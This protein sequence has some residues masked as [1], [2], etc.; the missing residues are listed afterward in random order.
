MFKDMLGNMPTKTKEHRQQ[1]LALVPSAPGEVLDGNA[2][3][4]GDA[5]FGH[6]SE[7]G[8]NYRNACHLC[9]N[10]SSRT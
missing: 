1:D 5:V 10:K 6:A 7:D 4:G 8:P 9:D 3:E 2:A